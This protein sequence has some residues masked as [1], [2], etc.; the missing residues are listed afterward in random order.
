VVKFSGLIVGVIVYKFFGLIVGVIVLYVGVS[1]EL[2]VGVIISL[3]Q[4]V[5]YIHELVLYLK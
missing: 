5:I 3:I 4:I 2:I 1:T